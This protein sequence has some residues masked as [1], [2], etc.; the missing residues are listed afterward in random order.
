M[1]RI[2]IIEDTANSRELLRTVLERLGHVVI[3][4]SDG[5]EAL[6][7]L[8]EQ[9]FDLIL[10]DLTIPPPNGYEVLKAIRNN[11]HSSS[12]PV[13]ALTAHAMAEERERIL[14]AGFDG[15]LIKPVALTQL[16]SEVERLLAQ[17]RLAAKPS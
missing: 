6:R 10:L 9:I 8:Q 11:H 16:R 14:A 12:V 17:G 1:K 3:E 2:L 15:Y 4:A 7:S 13:I 5:Q